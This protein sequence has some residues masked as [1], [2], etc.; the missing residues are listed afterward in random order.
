[1]RPPYEA[2]YWDELTDREKLNDLVHKIAQLGKVPYP[3][4]YQIAARL[5]PVAPSVQKTW[6]DRLQAAGMLQT[7][8]KKLIE[9]HERTTHD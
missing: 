8:I 4:A 6:P 5:V 7:A 3:E 2:P 9:Y 1:M